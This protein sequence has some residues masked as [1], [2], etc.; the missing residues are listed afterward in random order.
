[1]NL[2]REGLWACA[3]GGPESPAPEGHVA[4]F[5]DRQGSLLAF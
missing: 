4:K 3:A 5:Y 2:D 1:M